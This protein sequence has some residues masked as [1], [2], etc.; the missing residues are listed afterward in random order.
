MANIAFYLTTTLIWGATWLAIKFQVGQVPAA[1][2]VTYR[3]GLA[4][5]LL[6]IYC[7]LTK[8]S[9]KIKGP[10]HLAM[11]LQGIFLFSGNYLLFYVGTEYLVS[12]IVAV[13]AALIAV[14]NIINARLFFKT[15]FSLKIVIGALL[16]ILGLCEV[17]WS[18]IEAATHSQ[19]GLHHML[20]GL[21]YCIVATYVA[22]IGNMIAKRN[23]MY[24]L[25]ILQSSA[26]SMCYGALF[27]ALMA[28]L[29]KQPISFDTS[30]IYLYSLLYLAL[31]GT[32]IAF[33]CYLKLLGTIGPERV[34]YIFVIT[35]ILAM[36]ISTFF[37]KF[38]WQNST[39]IGIGLIIIGNILVLAKSSPK[40]Q[41]L[42]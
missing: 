21:G 40:N 38:Y 28:I 7:L 36:L 5:I 24:Q 17:F 26:Y 32:V 18:Q 34:A 16:G 22:S 19:E 23:Q 11:I 39:F 20:I 4:G 29:M 35:P 8:K 14:M 30:P 27:T 41:P 3:F 33:G 2:S 25:P 31:F 9:L 12:G 42:T 10:D 15:P 1:W 37:E 6:I 13:I